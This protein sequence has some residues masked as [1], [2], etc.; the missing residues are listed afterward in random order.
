MAK[1]RGRA[2]RLVGLGLV[3]TFV[4]CVGPLAS[5][6]S[7]QDPVALPPPP[8]IDIQVIDPVLDSVAVTSTPAT[9]AGDAGYANAQVAEAQAQADLLGA[10]RE[11]ID[12]VNRAADADSVVRT[13][14]GALLRA[15]LELDRQEAVLAERVADRRR[16]RE[17]LTTEQD[18]LRSLVGS[19]FASTPT[20]E[21][22]GL[23]TFDQLTEDQRRQDVRNRTVDVQVTLV[24]KR[25]AALLDAVTAE[26]VQST[27]VDEATVARDGAVA[28][29][30]A[31][32]STRDDIEA[33]LRAA[34]EAVTA[35]GADLVTSQ[36]RR[37]AALTERRRARLLAPVAGVDMTLVDLHAYW[38]G[39][40][41]APCPIPWWVL[42]GIGS[43]ES[44]H[45]TAQGATVGPDGTTTKR[46][47]GIALDGR[48]GVATIGDS[49]GGLLDGDTTFDRAVGPMQFIPSTWARWG[50]DGNL[51]DVSDPHN[52][53]DT[54]AAA[55]NYLCF[56]RANVT[57]GAAI[58]AALLSYN[59]SL[60][61][62]AK[63]TSI[64]RGYLSALGLPDMPPEDTTADI[65]TELAE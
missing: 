51:D 38:L 27:K 15:E 26:N 23:G 56:G 64:G 37:R 8:P 14:E 17:A 29:L 12:L 6:T 9:R 25:T 59:R 36:E 65:L 49:D 34:E 5:P 58:G 42:A 7:A 22:V 53:Y 33:L 30:A 31:A 28:E 50:R 45:G 32:V 63:V 13:A 35:R 41:T 20:D 19:V 46:I 21:I 11:Q 10:Q 3:S 16:A 60:P 43:V 2:V 48:P 39:S 1:P 24:D 57:D 40:A 47:L 4:V 18:T 55:A 44:G 61:Y 62:G 54:A 52:L